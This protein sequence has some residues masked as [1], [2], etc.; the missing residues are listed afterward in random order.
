MM[1][2]FIRFDPLYV[3]DLHS[4]A[5]FPAYVAIA[6]SAAPS[7]QTNPTVSDRDPRRR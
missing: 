5:K 7:P 4:D 1:L 2:G 6:P 3:G